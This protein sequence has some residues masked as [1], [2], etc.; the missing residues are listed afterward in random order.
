MYT[1]ESIPNL[2]LLPPFALSMMSTNGS[3]R[4]PHMGTCVDCGQ[5]AGATKADVEIS[6]GIIEKNIGACDK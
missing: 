5:E 3:R 6:M 4:R 1:P 2:C